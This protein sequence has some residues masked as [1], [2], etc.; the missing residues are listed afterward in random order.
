[1]PAIGPVTVTTHLGPD[2][3]TFVSMTGH[4]V[5]GRPFDYVVDLVSEDPNVKIDQLLGQA[6]LVSLEVGDG[7]TRHFHGI[8]TEIDVVE[9]PRPAT[10][11]RATL[12]PWLWL[13]GNNS[14]CR[15]FQNVSVPDIIQRVFKD[16]GF[17]DFE[18]SLTANYP[19][20]EYVVQYRESD[21]KFVSRLMEHAGIYYF[22][23]HTSSTHMLVLADAHGAHD[24]H[25]GYDSLPYAPPDE[26]RSSLVWTVDEWRLTH[27]MTSGAVTLRDFDFERPNA[28]LTARDANRMDYAGSGFEVYDYPGAYR[29]GADGNVLARLRLDQ[30]Q[31]S[32]A[33]TTGHTNARTFAAGGLFTLTE[34]PRD[35]QNAKYLVIGTETTLTGHQVTSGSQVPSSARDGEELTF[36]CNFTAIPSSVPFRTAPTTR[37]PVVD[38]PQTAIVVGP[39][40][41][42][43]F[44]DNYGRA[45]VQFHWDRLGKSDENS[46]CW[47]RVAQAWAGAQW[48][49]I[50]TPRI[51]QEVIVDFL[52]GDPDRPI[53]TGRVYNA[54]H[55]PPYK[56]PDNKTQSGIKSQSSKGGE[57]A[58][59]IRL[60]D[61]KGKEL[62]YVQAQKD[63]QTEVKHNETRH[64]AASQSISV[65]GSRSLAVGG[66]ETI[67][68]GGGDK[69]K[70]GNQ[71]ISVAGERKRTVA[72][73]DTVELN[74]EHEITVTKKVTQ[75]YNDDQALTVGGTQ[76]I[77]ITKDKKEHVTQK[78]ALTTD[79]EFKLVQNGDSLLMHD[80]FEL[81][82]AG[83]IS[84]QN[85][86][87]SAKL[88]SGKITLTA[89][90]ELKL[91]CGQASITLKQDG[92]IQISGTQKVTVASGSNSVE[93]SIASTKVSGIQVDVEG[94]A[95][96]T[97]KGAIVQ[98]N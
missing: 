84:I 67:S 36:S 97:I 11:Y 53:I 31:S 13:L 71:T 51:G 16:Q 45:K 57:G 20:L 88:D 74:D 73:K 86:D 66:S 59:E 61:L 43:I 46:S 39:S 12:R 81:Q 9:N 91:V 6:M 89:Q 70:P 87:C 80:K 19:K 49:S 62:F 55:M 96:T 60:E 72:K 63:L 21:L 2:V 76:T 25:A 37:K 77:E 23:K 48:G 34:Y 5:L 98:I 10:L 33:V 32:F 78:Y 58:N 35:D 3:L 85:D 27:R 75:N 15:I 30:I 7:S 50:F 8:V 4:E 38:G 93:T 94:Q 95:M 69:D 79:Q 44:T 29:T 14:D 41:E 82:S 52:E 17:T 24:P 83:A 47:I 26:H 28:D 65:D 68:I 42:E 92:T 22:F 64:V 1:M 18:V 56:L 90:S 40:G 54:T